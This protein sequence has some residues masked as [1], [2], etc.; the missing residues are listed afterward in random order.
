LA[1]AA[2]GGRL[3][4]GIVIEMYEFSQKSNQP[5]RDSRENVFRKSLVVPFSGN[6]QPILDEF[7]QRRDDVRLY[8]QS[9]RAAGV[10]MP[11]MT[12]NLDIDFSRSQL[13]LLI[14]AASLP[15]HISA[16]MTSAEAGSDTMERLMQS[17]TVE[18]L[19]VVQT[20]KTDFP[21]G[22]DSGFNN[23]IYL[24]SEG[25]ISAVDI[26]PPRLAFGIDSEKQP[27]PLPSDRLL[28]NYPEM[29]S[30]DPA[31]LDRLK[32]WYY[33]RAGTLEH[34]YSWAVASYFADSSRPLTWKDICNEPVP[35]NLAQLVCDLARQD[36][37]TQEADQLRSWAGSESFQEHISYRLEAVRK[38][39]HK[40]KGSGE[41][42]SRS[43]FQFSKRSSRQIPC[44]HSGGL[45]EQDNPPTTLVLAA[46]G[47]GSRMRSLGKTYP[48]PLVPDPIQGRPLLIHML[49]RLKEVYEI[50][51]IVIAGSNDTSTGQEVFR[52]LR[53]FPFS[54]RPDV[55][56]DA[57]DRLG[58]VEAFYRGMQ[59]ALD[60]NSGDIVLSVSD[61][62]AQDYQALLNPKIPVLL[63]VGPFDPENPKQY[64]VVSINEDQDIIYNP[65]RDT[66]PNLKVLNGVFRLKKGNVQQVHHLIQEGFLRSQDDRTL[67]HSNG[68]LRLTW[69]WQEIEAGGTPVGIAD[70]GEF[71]EINFPED[72]QKFRKFLNESQ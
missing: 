14:D 29:E 62:V 11:E 40:F 26:Y 72:L 61:T 32:R 43:G 38:R 18:M 5:N 25:R 7:Q 59:R 31:Q 19:K 16:L 71:V 24:P 33:T 20:M 63:G 60:L 41:F 12:I 70:L 46:G 66:S 69:V 51:R 30:L 27:F 48:K 65:C 1:E 57:G 35:G 8:Y 23:F 13:E 36:G 56:L 22:Y 58:V 39:Y 68:E 28:I 21:I 10:T 67:L 45:S 47:R 37:F 53:D 44:F 3:K 42:D 50:E 9:L 2:G 4:A 64:V 54:I 49:E 52:F 34:I 17:L 6:V 55:V 15:T